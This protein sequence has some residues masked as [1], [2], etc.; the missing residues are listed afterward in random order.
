MSTP[1]GDHGAEHDRDACGSENV[2]KAKNTIQSCTDIVLIISTYECH[3][4]ALPID[5]A[6][7]SDDVMLCNVMKCN[8]MQ[9]DAM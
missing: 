9:C 5:D 3:I 7:R 8:S 1:E 2:D 4:E 6:N